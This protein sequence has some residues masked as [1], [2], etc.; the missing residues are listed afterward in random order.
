MARKA[1]Y[2]ASS[3]LNNYLNMNDKRLLFVTQEVAP[4]IPG[5]NVATLSKELL[6]KMHSKKFEVR[7]FMPKLCD[8]NER[9]NQLHEVIRLSGL[10]IPINDADHPLILK[11]AS[12]Q[13]SRIQVYFIDNDDYFQQEDSDVDS[14]GS[15][16]DD[17]D[18]RAIF[19][20]RGSVETVKKLRW[21]PKIVHCSGW[22]TALL[23][24]Y[25]R[26]Q[27]ADAPM[28]KKSKIVYS[29]L[30]GEITGKFDPEFLRKLGEDGVQKTEIKKFKDLECNTNLLHRMALEH[31][32]A[33]IFHS[34]PDPEL[35]KFAEEKGL[36]ILT[37]D[38]LG[39]NPTE[40][41]AEF[42]DTL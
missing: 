8:V 17:N 14:I 6:T 35:L 2:P 38:K 25:L 16:R 27:T 41:I 19:F 4:Y 39:D 42:Y 15:N 7:S 22:I 28:L 12:L 13:P 3:Q 32:N 29:V 20:A 11:V 36:A 10:N 9:R 33:V 1:T 31:A 40:A 26:K 34:E 30:P 37:P 23:P 5:S 18:E 24:L 21:D